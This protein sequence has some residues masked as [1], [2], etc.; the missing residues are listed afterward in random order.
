MGSS[1]ERECS[2]PRSS[3]AT[4]ATVAIPRARHAR[5]T[6]SAISPRFATRSFRIGTAGRKLDGP[7]PDLLALSALVRTDDRVADL[8]R[9]VAVLERGPVRRSEEHTSELQSHS[10]L[11]C[12][13]L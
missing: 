3:A 12:R 1:A 11:V 6:R 2:A 8:G 4:T 10:D 7:V 9:A 5:K 13:L